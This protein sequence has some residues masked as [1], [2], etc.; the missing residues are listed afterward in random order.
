MPTS[1]KK[2]PANTAN[3]QSVASL[4]RKLRK[5]ETERDQ[6]LWLHAELAFKVRSMIVKQ[7]MDNPDVRQQ[8]ESQLIARMGAKPVSQMLPTA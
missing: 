2:T 3:P 7:M 1:A 6:A 5:A 8:L 4:K